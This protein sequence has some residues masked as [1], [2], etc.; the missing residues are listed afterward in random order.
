MTQE[1]KVGPG[2]RIGRNNLVQAHQL[3][4][5]AQVHRYLDVVTVIGV[6]VACKHVVVMLEHQR[7]IDA[8]THDGKAQFHVYARGPTR[9]ALAAQNLVVEVQGVGRDTSLNANTELCHGR[10]R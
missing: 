3:Q 2:E 7:A 4:L 10:Q 1:T 9:A 6:A 8:Q 5:V